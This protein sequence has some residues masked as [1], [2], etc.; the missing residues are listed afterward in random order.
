MKLFY[1]ATSPF[2][3]KVMVCAIT[4]GLD[5]LIT[6]VSTNPH[7]SPP[8]LLAANPLSKVP[9]LVTN[10]GLALFD[11]PVICEYLDSVGDE[12]A[13]F[14]RAGTGERWIAVKLQALGDGMMDAAVLR[15]GLQALPQQA[16]IDGLM[17]RQAA[18]VANSLSL[19][20]REPP[21]RALDIGSISVACA[22]G[23]LDFRFAHEPWRETC[24]KL[25]AWF[26]HISGEAGIAQTVPK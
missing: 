19:L 11:S 22:L 9:C 13:L 4:R 14:P 17:A 7:T 23:Y 26:D 6:K 24:P 1:S 20:E 15:R 5:G 18:A 2:V 12:P 16:S 8:E 10:D 25:S 3:R 21:H